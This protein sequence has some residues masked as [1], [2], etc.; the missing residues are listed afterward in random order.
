VRAL[1]ERGRISAQ[2]ESRSDMPETVKQ[3]FE[4]LARE[5]KIVKTKQFRNGQPVYVTREQA[6]PEEIAEQEREQLA[7]RG[8]REH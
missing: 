6:T 4:A 3:T 7:E 2:M 5:G 8:E 1:T